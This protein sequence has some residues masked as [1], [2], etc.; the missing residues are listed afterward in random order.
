MT[1]A[2]LSGQELERLRLKYAGIRCQRDIKEGATMSKGSGRGNKERTVR[3]LVG[4]YS[5]K[6]KS[7]YEEVWCIIAFR[8]FPEIL[9]PISLSE[10]EKII[11]T[12]PPKVM[13]EKSIHEK[14]CR[15][16]NH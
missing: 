7:G 13:V 12:K 2:H 11:E 6:V 16:S 3:G 9:C 14:P 4:V 5:L 10:V 15:P 8:H 1:R